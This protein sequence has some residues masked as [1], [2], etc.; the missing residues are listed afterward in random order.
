MLDK[1][2]ATMPENSVQPAM[3]LKRSSIEKQPRA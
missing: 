1:P 3:V 2:S